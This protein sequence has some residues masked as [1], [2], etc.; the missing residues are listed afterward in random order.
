VRPVNNE[1]RLDLDERLRIMRDGVVNNSAVLVSGVTGIVL[2]PVMLKG[3]GVEAYGVWLAAI[4]VAA[5]AGG[6][7]LGLG[8]SVTREV[9]GQASGHGEETDRLIATAYTLFLALGIVGAGVIVAIGTLLSERLRL[10]GPTRDAAPLVFSLVAVA[11]AGERLVGLAL[12]ILHGLRQFGTANLVSIATALLRAAG[13]VGLLAAG[14]GVVAVA[15]WHAAAS[16]AVAAGAL[17][18]ASRRGGFRSRPSGFSWSVVRSHAAFSFT[19][20]LTTMAIKLIWEAAPVV[21]GALR[22]ASAIVPYHI[23]QKFPVAVSGVAWRSAEVVFPA[24][25]EYERA[26]DVVRSRATLEV[27]TRWAIVLTLPFALVLCVLADPL[28]KA[29][30]GEADREAV[31][32]LR[33]VT[34]AVLADSVGVAALH[35]LWGRGAARH[36]LTVLVAVAV[37][38]LGLSVTLVAGIG[39]VGAAWG[40]F[41]PMLL[42]SLV[43]LSLGARVCEVELL[44]LLRRTVRGLLLPSVISAALAVAV[45][46]LVQPTG[47]PGVVVAA[48]AS[49]TAYGVVLYVAGARPEERVFVRMIW[50]FLATLVLEKTHAQ[51]GAFRRL[52]LARSTW[53]LLRELREVFMDS[54][55]RNRAAASRDF[56]RSRDP[57]NY[58][59]PRED[60]RLQV[61]AQLL[62]S[63]R[64]DSLFVDALEIGC[65]EGAFTEVLAPKCRSLLAVD[66][67][68]VA[69]ARARERCASRA[70]VRF[71]QWD[72]RRDP[73]PGQFDLIVATHVLDYIARPAALKAIRAKLVEALRPG[74]VLLVGNVRQGEVLERAWWAR[75]LV[76]GGK[77]IDAFMADHANVR[78]V[79]TQSD[80]RYIETVLQK[81]A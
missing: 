32:I 59:S 29:W 25:S 21:I 52:W 17:H 27:G 69:L 75:R 38:S 6:V 66:L 51:R 57:W 78:V 45:L 44:G 7:D 53:H 63:V 79:A 15:A 14:A 43:F 39:P 28:L 67:S 81:I 2:V 42:G 26:T 19:S 56:E 46:F 31:T 68:P 20:Q 64:G 12:A 74:G 3:L 62:D 10:S 58:A 61:E 5:L 47:W 60:R 70:H 1:E 23:G 40:L 54:P 13:I 77:W 34:G 35:V 22:G 11:L 16:L 33:L 9:A 24:A 55:T 65:A 30:I 48:F 18:I 50:T 76:R 49:G 8:W 37:A 73:V 72:L 4:A 71:L 36:V 80:D 41:V